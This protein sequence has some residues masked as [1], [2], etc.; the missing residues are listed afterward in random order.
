M[1]DF[2]NNNTNNINN[3]NG[4]LNGFDSVNGNETS[5]SGYTVTPGRRL[6]HKAPRRYNSGRG[7]RLKL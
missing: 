4:E 7:V 1:D 6:L 3:Q 2:N 5:Q